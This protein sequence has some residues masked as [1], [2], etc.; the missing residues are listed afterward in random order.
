M[1][2]ELNTADTVTTPTPASLMEILGEGVTAAQEALE[3]AQAGNEGEARELLT[4]AQEKLDAGQGGNAAHAKR[5][6]KVVRLMDEAAALLPAKNGEQDVATEPA[7]LPEAGNPEASKPQRKAQPG[8]HRPAPP[9]GE[10][11]D[12]VAE[13]LRLLGADLEQREAEALVLW[14]AVDKAELE[15]PKT[16]FWKRVA[17][18]E[19]LHTELE[20][21]VLRGDYAAAGEMWNRIFD[22]DT[23]IRSKAQGEKRKGLE[24]AEEKMAAYEAARER[25]TR[26]KGWLKAGKTEAA[27]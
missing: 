19:A 16:R 11:W 13:A 17:E 14:T 9:T 15:H 4:I 18:A 20:V 6:E 23:N 3:A 1:K 25:T 7:T 2:N 8:S 10:Q 22:V 5:R 12:K 24:G 27:A 26:L 21:A